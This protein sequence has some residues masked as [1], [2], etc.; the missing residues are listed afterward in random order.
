M[1][2]VRLM[3]TGFRPFIVKWKKVVMESEELSAMAMLQAT[4]RAI[5]FEP[6]A[7]QEGQTAHIAEDSEVEDQNRFQRQYDRSSSASD[8]EGAEGSG[9]DADDA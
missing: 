5:G 2:A 1:A 8:S 7:Q 9:P 6:A 3:I 4:E